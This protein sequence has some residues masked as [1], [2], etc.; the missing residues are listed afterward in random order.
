M[1]QVSDTLLLDSS[2]NFGQVV[3]VDFLG[4]KSIAFVT[5]KSSSLV[6]SSLNNVELGYLNVFVPTTPNPTSGYMVIVPSSSVVFLPLSVEQ[7]LK[8]VISMGSVNPETNEND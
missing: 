8:H 4:S 7:A 2:T 3:L 1:K 6:T 5:G